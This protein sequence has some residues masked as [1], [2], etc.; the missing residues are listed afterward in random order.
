M[1]NNPLD[2]IAD[3]PLD[4]VAPNP[5]DAVATEDEGARLPGV[6][7]R[8]FNVG[9]ADVLGA[10]SDIASQT[11][12]SIGDPDIPE[13]TKAFR[14][15]RE[16]FST[17]QKEPF[18]GSE[19]IK[20][21][22][23]RLSFIQERFEP[24]TPTE[25]I[26]SRAGE[27]AGAL[28]PFL[29]V[30]LK[31]SQGVKRLATEAEGFVAN[32]LKETAENP[33]LVSAVE[34]FVSLTAGF[35]AGAAKEMFPDSPIAELA[36]GILGI[37]G[38]IGTQTLLRKTLSGVTPKQA[39]L[40]TPSQGKPVSDIPD[41]A[42]NINLNNFDTTADAKKLMRQ[43][44]QDN[45]EFIDARRGEISLEE[46]ERMAR[47][48]IARDMNIGLREVGEA[49]NAEELTGVRI[50]LAESAENVV[51][52]SRRVSSGDA[53]VTELADYQA[54]L[55]RHAALQE[56]VSGATAEAGRALSALRITAKTEKQRLAAIDRLIKEGGGEKNIR[57]LADKIR[58]FND[59]AAL[60]A[61]V[62]D[63]MKPT[64]VDKAQEVWINWL[65]SGPQTHV[66]NITSNTLFS[67]WQMPERLLAAGF[68]KVGS[69]EIKFTEIPE[70]MKGWIEGT[71]EGT[72]LAKQ[73]FASELPSRGQR[74][75][76]VERP[77]GAISGTTGRLVRLPGRALLAEDEFFKSIGYRMEL[78]TLAGRIATKEGLKGEARSA[79]VFELKR[80]PTPEMIDKAGFNA[81][82][83]TFTQEL[84]P[85]GKN[86]LA[87]T[88]DLPVMR[89]VV[90]FVRTP[91]NIVKAGLART[92]LAPLT[93]GFREQIKRGGADREIALAR[94]ALG[95]M[96]GGA[97]TYLAS[98]GLMTGAGPSD[99]ATRSVWLVDHQPFSAKIGDE[100]VSYGRIEPAAIVM[101]LGAD[102][103][104]VL[105]FATEKER[106]DL[107]VNLSFALAKN[108]TN[109]TFLSGISDAIEAINDPDRNG[110]GYIRKLAGTVVPSV[111]AQIAREVDPVLR[112][113]TADPLSDFKTIEGIINQIKSR[114]PGFSDRL[115]ARID[116]WGE[117]IVF[118]GGLGPDL[119]SPI[120]TKN[121]RND[122][123][124][125]ELLR[126]D[127]I[128][129]RLKR[130][131]GGAELKPEE[132]KEMSIL[133]G[134]MMRSL[135]E[136]F[137]NSSGYDKIPDLAK[138]KTLEQM[139]RASRDFANAKMLSN[140]AVR[141]RVIKAQKEK[142]I[143]R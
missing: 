18:L 132:F 35:G 128:P 46:T 123:P 33:A 131:I 4:A 31:A 5:L 139:M 56:Q 9:I 105:P 111:S 99:S 74:K 143:G 88:R 85:A 14:P 8:G 97:S 110:E 124:T 57:D 98:Q 84:G 117:P 134:K 75:I 126:L 80:D 66:V 3:N 116:M 70:M 129:G 12:G 107:V 133:A 77:A 138:E 61:F 24:Q 87:I 20:K 64:L 72:R 114:I 65:L 89:I 81:D 41:K 44:A 96:I 30:Q 92:P 36:G 71:V 90:P 45:K 119:I 63:A 40:E 79:R 118:E 104:T 113:T 28:V 109:K 137:I 6:A 11:I 141:N 21:T 37:F 73:S 51:G 55:G 102:L 95:T 121:W 67:L 42:G 49:L 15:I 120:Y 68:S 54:L 25:R 39:V 26:V 1:A 100:W 10:P 52:Q 38:G 48:E 136:P 19:Q 58:T 91:V 43:T 29:G 47:E 83:N 127:V 103:A 69:K 17:P 115:P 122:K 82:Y 22:F 7:A 53:T 101:G 60:N 2:A 108:L 23:R 130:E 78:N 142:A 140:E 125:Q 59:P 32:I 112:D 76:D 106:D 93:K 34:S 50:M 86:F 62:K 94:I 13:G 16:F 27:E 135:M